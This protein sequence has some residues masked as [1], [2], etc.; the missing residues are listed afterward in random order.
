MFK[1]KFKLAAGV[2]AL[3]PVFFAGNAMAQATGYT[4]TTATTTLFGNDSASQQGY[5]AMMQALTSA[6]ISFTFGSLANNAGT[7][8]QIAQGNTDGANGV[9]RFAMPGQGL[10]GAAA[11]GHRARWNGWLSLARNSIAYKFQPLRSSGHVNVA[12]AGIDYTFGNNAVA[13]VSFTRDRG[14]I[15][16][17]FIGGKLDSKGYMVSPYVA[18]PLTKNLALSATAGWG[19]SD[20]DVD[21]G[22]AA[23]AGLS[24]DS[25]S[26]RR[27]YGAGLNYMGRADRLSYEAK[28]TYLNVRDRLGAYTMSNGAGAT[29]GVNSVVTK[30]SQG[31]LGAQL[32]YDFGFLTPYLGMD[33]VYDFKKPNDDLVNGLKPKADRDGVV[34]TVGLKFNS[35]GAL[36]GSVQYSHEASRDQVKNNQIMLN[37]GARF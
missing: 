21:L 26:K 22:N 18:I 15:N 14:D 27:M 5:Q 12:T 7:F 10:T 37:L 33:Y 20:I 2:L 29:Q 34:G 8:V 17:D 30:V 24:G 16:L 11:A 36:Y 25:D 4:T 3:A 6:G 9:Q 1:T 28:A 32:G 35:K 13:G 31:R 19:T 23:G